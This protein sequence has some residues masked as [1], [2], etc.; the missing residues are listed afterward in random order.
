MIFYT[1]EQRIYGHYIYTNQL[2]KKN[3]KMTSLTDLCD[4][5]FVGHGSS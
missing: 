4:F 3:T 2:K 5:L 1:Q